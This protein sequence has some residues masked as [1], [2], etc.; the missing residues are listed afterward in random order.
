MPDVC[1]DVIDLDES[2]GEVDNGI[3][4]FNRNISCQNLGACHRILRVSTVE[5][6]F[7]LTAAGKMMMIHTQHT[8]TIR[9]D[10]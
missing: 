5:L 10:T 1:R 6:K 2:Q 4:G 8:T 3:L 9:A 7:K